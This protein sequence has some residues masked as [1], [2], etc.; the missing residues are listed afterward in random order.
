MAKLGAASDNDIV[1]HS[2]LPTDLMGLLRT[3]AMRT[4][5]PRV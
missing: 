2:S 5:F 1:I 3:D 4:Y